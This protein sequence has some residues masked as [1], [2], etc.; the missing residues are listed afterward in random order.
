MNGSDAG[1]GV[2]PGRR[3]RRAPRRIDV[4]PARLLM[5]TTTNH[6]WML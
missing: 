5:L 2:M 3:V 4:N 1:T 6:V